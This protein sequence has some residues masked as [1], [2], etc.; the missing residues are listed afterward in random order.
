[1]ICLNFVTQLNIFDDQVIVVL[2]KLQNY[3]RDAELQRKATYYIVTN[4]NETHVC[5]VVNAKKHTKT[6]KKNAIQI[7]NAMKSLKL[8]VISEF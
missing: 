6:E 3:K 4:I 7:L 8:T 1:M 2:L 5:V